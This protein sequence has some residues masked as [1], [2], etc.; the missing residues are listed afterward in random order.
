MT[1]YKA[2]KARPTRRPSS[3]ISLAKG[4]EP[5]GTVNED[6]RVAQ[7]PPAAQAG[8]GTKENITDT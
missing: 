6:G 4:Q 8:H 5:V 3:P 7:G 2:I 1:V